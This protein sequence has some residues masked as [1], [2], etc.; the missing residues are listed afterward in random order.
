MLFYV[1]WNNELY[2]V[3]WSFFVLGNLVY[4][5]GIHEKLK[6]IDSKYE[7]LKIKKLKRNVVSI[8]K[9]VEYELYVNIKDII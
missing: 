8:I 6:L 9:E 4:K 7:K 2:S 3:W 5:K 1:Y